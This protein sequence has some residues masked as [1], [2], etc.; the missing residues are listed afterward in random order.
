VDI[1][2]GK[3]ESCKEEGHEEEGHQKEKVVFYTNVP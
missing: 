2:A 1:N 3:E